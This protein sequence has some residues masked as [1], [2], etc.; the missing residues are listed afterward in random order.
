[1]ATGKSVKQR[2]IEDAK[3]VTEERRM[4]NDH[5]PKFEGIVF[6]FILCTAMTMNE[7]FDRFISHARCG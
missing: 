6:D 4:S 2:L 5:S 3:P 1:M 7:T